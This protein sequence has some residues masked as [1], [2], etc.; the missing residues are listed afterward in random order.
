MRDDEFSSRLSKNANFAGFTPLHYAALSD[1]FECIK[2]LLDA[3]MLLCSS[4][5]FLPIY[6]VPI[7]PKLRVLV[8]ILFYLDFRVSRLNTTK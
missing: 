2:L 4:V 8:R 6:M 1:D 5:E 7:L 3:G